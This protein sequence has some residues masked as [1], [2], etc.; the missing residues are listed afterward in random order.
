MYRLLSSGGHKNTLYRVSTLSYTHQKVLIVWV[1]HTC[2][3]ALKQRL[4][5]KPDKFITIDYA[6]INLAL[7]IQQRHLIQ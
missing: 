1:I 6:D 3:A 7:N 4:Q 5:K 2:G